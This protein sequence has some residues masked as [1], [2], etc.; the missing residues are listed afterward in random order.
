MSRFSV[1]LP[2]ALLA[3]FVALAVPACTHVP[4]TSLVALS[5]IDFATTDLA[6]FRAAMRFPENYRARENRMIVTGAIEGQPEIKET[7]VLSPINDPDEL[8]QLAGERQAGAQIA[9]FRLPPEA[10]ATFE[11]H[12]RR[13]LEAKR[14]KRKGS[15][16][17]ALEPDFC[18]EKTPPRDTLPFSTFLRTSE[19]RRYVTV[20]R[21][22]DAFSQKE[23]GARLR[24][25]PAC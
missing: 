25:M 17:I 21:D 11:A 8:N 15:L 23:Y 10:V 16:S 1:P 5:R 7:F 13:A 4:V 20:L 24:G 3:P 9:A 12:R 22:L 19:T 6:S 14:E 2:S 18:Y